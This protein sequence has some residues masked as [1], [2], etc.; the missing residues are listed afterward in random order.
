VQSHEISYYNSLQ[1]ANDCCI[2]KFILLE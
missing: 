2:L 1:M